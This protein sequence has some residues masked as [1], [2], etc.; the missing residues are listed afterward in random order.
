[1]RRDLYSNIG[2]ATAILPAVKSAAGDGITVDTKGYASLTFVITTGAI[3][4]A[5]DFGVAVQ[6]SDASGSGFT[7]AGADFV[8]SNAPATLAA[9]SVY[10]VSYRGNKRYARL[11][12][13]KAGGTSIALGAVAVLGH[14]EVSPVA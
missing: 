8:D 10:K 11:Q 2:L 3:A 1:M 9:D 6:D 12:L 5:G 14:P 13:T 4:S 7:A